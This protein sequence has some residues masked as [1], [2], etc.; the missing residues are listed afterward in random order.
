MFST[1]LSLALCPSDSSSESS[2]RGSQPSSLLVNDV[3]LS[4]GW[5][6]V[7]GRAEKRVSKAYRHNLV[8]YHPHT[9]YLSMHISLVKELV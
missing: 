2:T 5:E 3:R 6:N 9:P 1:S 8:A 4:L 7:N